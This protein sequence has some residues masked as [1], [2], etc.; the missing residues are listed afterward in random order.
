M[1]SEE[2]LNILSPRSCNNLRRLLTQYD[3]PVDM[4]VGYPKYR[5]ILDLVRGNP[6]QA[7]TPISLK[8]SGVS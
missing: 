7:G 1:I 8:A 3:V 2:F 5:A 4:R 6:T